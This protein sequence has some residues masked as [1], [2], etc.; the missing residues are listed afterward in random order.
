MPNVGQTAT[1]PKT[2][3]K[4]KWDGEGW[5][6]IVAPKAAPV[7]MSNPDQNFLNNLSTTAASARETQRV[8]EQTGKDV[9]TLKPG[10]NR[11]RFL[12]IAT[13]E[14]GG[15]FFDTLGAIAIG[16][17]ARM[18]GAIKPEETDA[19]QRLRGLQSQQVL[20]RQLAQKGPQTE[21]DAARLML[22]EISPSKSAAVNRSIVE[23]GSWKTKRD[24]AKAVFYGRFANKWGLHGTSPHGHTADEIW[25]KQGD[26]ITKM[27][28]DKPQGGTGTGIRVLSRTKVK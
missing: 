2:G 7:K 12:E 21:S 11:G 27:L 1:N 26:S 3:Q 28:F 13:P 18:L 24:Q 17:P 10:P 15:G 19:Y 23:R 14:E 8:Y 9:K 4:V 22:T 5:V 20:E 25:A 6:S 16:G